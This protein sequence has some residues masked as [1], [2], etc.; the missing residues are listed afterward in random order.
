MFWIRPRPEEVFFV[1]EGH[2]DWREETAHSDL[3]LTSLPDGATRRIF[4]GVPRSLALIACETGI[5]WAQPAPFPGP[6]TRFYAS[7][8][9][10]SVRSLGTLSANQRPERCVE[11]GGRLLWTVTTLTPPSELSTTLMSANIDGTDIRSVGT[12]L[13]GHPV[14]IQSLYVYQGSLYSVFTEIPT[15]TGRSVKVT[16]YVG[17]LHPNRSDSVEIVHALPEDAWPIQFDGRYLY[18][19]LEGTHRSFLSILF[20]AEVGH[21]EATLCRILVDH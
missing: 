13:R 19:F 14:H 16:Y 2:T 18:F 11:V 9:D 8:S 3:M 12:Q 21:P 6:Q 10:S 4:A 15:E 1:R 17:R 5:V 7:A 20:N